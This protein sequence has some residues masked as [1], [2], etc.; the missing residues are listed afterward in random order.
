MRK[1]HRL[2]FLNTE[3][4]N[5][6]NVTVRLGTKWA[7]KCSVGDSFEIFKTGESK[8]ESFGVLEGMAILPFMN[9]PKQFLDLEHDSSC[10]D[11]IGLQRAMNA[12]YGDKFTPNSL[13]TVLMFRC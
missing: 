4:R 5:G 7:M 12:A 9:I 6:L 11:L 2:Y 10:H 8:P 1:T 3:M 13:C